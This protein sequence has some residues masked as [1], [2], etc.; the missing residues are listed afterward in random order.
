MHSCYIIE[1]RWKWQNRFGTPMV[2]PRS[3][4]VVAFMDLSFCADAV[5]RPYGGNHVCNNESFNTS[6]HHEHQ[7]PPPPPTTSGTTTPFFRVATAQGEQGIWMLNYLSGKTLGIYQKN[8]RNTSHTHH[9]IVAGNSINGRHQPNSQSKCKVW[10]RKR[11]ACVQT[12][13]NICHYIGSFFLAELI[14][15]AEKSL[16]F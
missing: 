7:S 13:T 1:F 15:E 3:D 8:I 5:W 9:C 10:W 12:E 6:F 2:N 4:A 14:S 11:Q 16:K